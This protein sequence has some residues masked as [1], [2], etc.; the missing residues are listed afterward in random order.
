MRRVELL[1][2]VGKFGVRRAEI[3]RTGRGSFSYTVSR[4]PH[5][6][7]SQAGYKAIW[8]W[9]FVSACRIQSQSLKV[10]MV[11]IGKEPGREPDIVGIGNLAITHQLAFSD[12][13]AK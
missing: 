12:D 9:V 1:F 5:T 3:L 4:Q 6:S 7:H 2:D 10:T 11:V 13:L 8:Q